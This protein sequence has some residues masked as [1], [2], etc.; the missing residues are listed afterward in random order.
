MSGFCSR[1]GLCVNMLIFGLGANYIENANVASVLPTLLCP[2]WRLQ[3]WGSVCGPFAPRLG[4]VSGQMA[5]PRLVGR[6]QC[7]VQYI[8]VGSK[9]EMVMEQFW[10]RGTVI[11]VLRMDREGYCVSHEGNP[12]GRCATPLQQLCR[13]CNDTLHKLWRYTFSSGTHHQPHLSILC[14]GTCALAIV[15]SS[16]SLRDHIRATHKTVNDTKTVTLQWRHKTHTELLY[17]THYTPTADCQGAD[18]MLL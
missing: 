14:I 4:T 12:D 10:R 15:S 16:Q 6:V 5:C 8:V 17:T 3:P 11:G 9:K 1:A 2:A 7:C 13:G 18:C